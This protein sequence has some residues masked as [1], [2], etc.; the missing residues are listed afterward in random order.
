MTGARE[1]LLRHVHDSLRIKR[2]MVLPPNVEEVANSSAYSSETNNA[3]LSVI[4]NCVA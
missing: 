3:A 4:N 1:K 2:E